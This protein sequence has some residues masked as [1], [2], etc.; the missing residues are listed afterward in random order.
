MKDLKS[1][2]YCWE[3]KQGYGKPPYS[4]LIMKFT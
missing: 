1:E 2:A 3:D 4:T